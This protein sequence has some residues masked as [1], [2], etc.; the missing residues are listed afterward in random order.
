MIQP[1]RE[2]NTNHPSRFTI[3]DTVRVSPPDSDSFAAK[4]DGVLFLEGKVFYLLKNSHTT[5]DSC[6]VNEMAGG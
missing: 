2:K 3:G 6:Y 5:W 4:V 1:H